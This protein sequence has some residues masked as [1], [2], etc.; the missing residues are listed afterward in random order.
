ME[1][2]EMTLQEVMERGVKTLKP[3][4]DMYN[5]LVCRGIL[6]M[7]QSGEYTYEIDKYCDSAYDSDK[8]GMYA[9]AEHTLTVGPFKFET[10]DDS[11]YN[12]YKWSLP[13]VIKALKNSELR[14]DI[15]NALEEIYKETDWQ[16]YWENEEYNYDDGYYEDE[17]QPDE[18][19]EEEEE[20][21]D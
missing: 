18:E 6:S 4:D 12:L 21:Q 16:K 10:T 2:N 11:N 8:C 7:L 9:Y 15:D 17:E 1:K 20:N 19:W 14:Y 3:E 13:A 5:E